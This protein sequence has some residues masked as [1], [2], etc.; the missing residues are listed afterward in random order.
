MTAV[1]P[2]RVNPEG[3]GGITGRKTEAAEK[4]ITGTCTRNRW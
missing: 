4:G 3:A 2:A 1:I